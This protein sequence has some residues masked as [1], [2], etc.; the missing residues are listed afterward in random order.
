MQ[1]VWIEPNSFLMGS[2]DSTRPAGVATE[3]GRREDETPHRVTLTRGF[4]LGAN[5]V[6]QYQWEQ[7]MG[8]EANRSF[9][10]AQTEEAKRRLPVDRVSWEDCQQF[11][12][13]LSA[14]EGRKYGLP[15]EAEWEYACR[16]GT[17]TAFWCGDTITTDLANYHGKFAYG[18]DGKQGD[19]RGRPTPIDFFPANPWGLYDMHGN[20]YQWCQDWYGPYPQSDVE[21]PLNTDCGFEEARVLRGGSWNCDAR[22]CRAA[23]RERDVPAGRIGLYGVRVSLRLD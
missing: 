21:D 3:E 15:T 9:F 23:Y 10:K 14:R 4:H 19:Y 17:T 5:L 1:F 8:Q 20:L 2:P 22:S 16:A 6:T 12:D 18:T 7:V 11:C 13:R